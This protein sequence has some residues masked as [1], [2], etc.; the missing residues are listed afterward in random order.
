MII[1]GSNEKD[2]AIAANNLI[3]TQGGLV[4]VNNGKTIAS[5]PLQFGGIISTDSFEKVSSNF[6]A[7]TNSIVDSGSVF[8]RPHLIPLFLPFLA[9]PSIRILYSGIV[10]VKKRSFVAPINK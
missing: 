3:K 2:M 6:S 9:L 4:V 7:I 8:K 5:L 10:D 1:I